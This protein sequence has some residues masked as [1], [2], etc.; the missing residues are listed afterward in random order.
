MGA[1]AWLLLSIAVGVAVADWVAV[2][3]G[4]KRLEYVFKPT[5]M[6]ALI[7]VAVVIQPAVPA[8]RAWWLAALVLGLT[9]DVFLVL[10]GDRF[11]AGLAAF[12]LGHLAYIAGFHAAGVPVGTSALW[13]A[14]LLVLAS[15]ALLPIVRGARRAGHPELAGP[16]VVYALVISAM[17]ASALAA[18]T[19]LGGAARLAAPGALLFIASDGLIGF[20][21]F[22]S[23]RPWMGLAVIV[24]YHLGQAALVVSLVR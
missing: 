12:L 20:R 8:Q 10:P 21:R 2:A 19:T 5:V 22:V 11:V 16:I 24:T 3:A 23:D 6:L 4:N 7:G 9:G 17:V 18:A 1:S 15:A 13:L 14:L